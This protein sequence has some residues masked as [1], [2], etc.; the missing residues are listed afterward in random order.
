MRKSSVAKVDEQTT[1]PYTELITKCGQVVTHPRTMYANNKPELCALLKYKL[2]LS[3]F[4]FHN[5]DICS[6][7]NA[8]KKL[9]I[10]WLI[11][12]WERCH[13]I[14]VASSTVQVGKHLSRHLA[15]CGSHPTSRITGREFHRW[16]YHCSCITMI[17]STVPTLGSCID[18]GRSITSL[19]LSSSSFTNRRG[20][21]QH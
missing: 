7:A 18:V 13:T 6:L 15:S 11:S 21:M 5:S 12:M 2:G 16:S 3:V 1:T 20:M 9:Q 8:K 10:S 19:I 17:Q 4:H 14:V